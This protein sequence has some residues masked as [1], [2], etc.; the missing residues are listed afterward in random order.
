MKKKSPA[1]FFCKKGLSKINNIGFC[2]YFIKTI[3]LFQVK[4]LHYLGLLMA[5]NE[6]CLNFQV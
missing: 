6:V 4:S 5:V 3:Y 2:L 1:N